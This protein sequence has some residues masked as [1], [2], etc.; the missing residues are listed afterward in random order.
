M[1]QSQAMPK[2]RLL[3]SALLL[4]LAHTAAA[5]QG[6]QARSA[7]ETDEA[8]ELDQ[9]LEFGNTN[10]LLLNAALRIIDGSYT[11]ATTKSATSFTQNL[12]KVSGSLDRKATPGVVIDIE[13]G[14]E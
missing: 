4:A 3:A 2:K 11:Q 14:Q 9:F 12:Q 6:Q 13:T 5:Q 10:E 8:T 7:S 1:N